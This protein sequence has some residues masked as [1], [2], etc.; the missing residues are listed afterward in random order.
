MPPWGLLYLSADLDEDL[1]EIV[2]LDVMLAAG[3]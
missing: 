1:D 3:E 2:A